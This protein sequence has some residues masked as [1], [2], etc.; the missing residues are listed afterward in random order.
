VA[1]S[2]GTRSPLADFDP[3]MPVNSVWREISARLQLLPF[4]VFVDE[5]RDHVAHIVGACED[6]EKFIP[7][8]F[9]ATFGVHANHVRRPKGPMACH[10]KR[11]LRELELAA[12]YCVAAKA[13]KPK[14][15]RSY[16]CA[17]MFHCAQVDALD[18]KFRADRK[19]G[20]DN[21]D[22][23]NNAVRIRTAR[24]I[25]VLAPAGGWRDVS[26]A[27]RAVEERLTDFI[28]QRRRFSMG[29][30]DSL[31]RTIRHWIRTHPLVSPAF[32]ATSATTR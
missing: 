7:T 4:P 10:A 2:A 16:L 32:M 12:A 17:A 18:A 6:L 24:L 5:F 15:L 21:L 22:T 29:W 30:G 13:Q 19:R 14:P 26:E 20:G 9:D 28:K 23:K 11:M 31:R 1:V 3:F 8:F 25:Y 27:A